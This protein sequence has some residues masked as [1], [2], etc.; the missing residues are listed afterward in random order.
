[1]KILVIL[2]SA[3][4]YTL[5]ALTQVAYKS[6]SEDSLENP[7]A[8]F[9][10]YRKILIYLVGWFLCHQLL[11]AVACRPVAILYDLR[12]NSMLIIQII[13]FFICLLFAFFLGVKFASIK[14]AHRQVKSSNLIA[15]NIV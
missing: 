11:T 5:I 10:W 1:M 6:A 13:G 3:G 7:Y 4:S 9:C 15:H 8:W 14:P 12:Y 2:L